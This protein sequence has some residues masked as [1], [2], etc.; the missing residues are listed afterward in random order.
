MKY[1]YHTST[2]NFDAL[3]CGMCI[4]PP[5]YY[6]E[7]ALWFPQYFKSGVDISS[8]I[9]ALYSN[10]VI[11][12]IDDSDMV[13]YPMV[14]ELDAAIVDREL[15]DPSH[16]RKIILPCG[17]ECIL[18]CVPIV[19]SAEDLIAGRVR[20]L[21]RS[22]S[23]K[24]ELVS[25]SNIGVSENKLANVFKGIGNDIVALIADLK[26]IDFNEVQSEVFDAINASGL[27]LT[28]DSF[29]SFENKDRQRGADAGF[30]AG[31]WV[32]SLREGFC[33]DCFPDAL[34]FASWKESLPKGIRAILDYVSSVGFRWDVNRN[35]ICNFCEKCWNACI[36]PMADGGSQD[37]ERWHKILGAIWKSYNDPTFCYPISKIQDPY[38]QALA[39]FM[40]AGRDAR[41]IVDIITREDILLPELSLSLHGALVGYCALSR[42]LFSKRSYEKE[43]KPELQV[44]KPR[45]PAVARELGAVSTPPA[46]I[47]PKSSWIQVIREKFNELIVEN[48]ISKTNLK[49]RSK[50]EQD[51]EEAANRSNDDANRF[52]RE[53]EIISNKRWPK[54][55]L[56]A[57]ADKLRYTGGLI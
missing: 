1:Y 50:L 10:P 56:K 31:W 15:S 9:V 51:I 20:F 7:D 11:W 45:K 47:K 54:K 43:C 3:Y 30:R 52:I 2:L 17:V 16:S 46:E 18:A 28:Q 6:Q 29:S 19:F 13:N 35:W 33:M 5:N 34:S 27:A 53:L 8:D 38:M 42:I 21:F 39:C 40:K 24:C 57:F 32:R 49:V 12:K 44:L 37:C 23:E 4:M 22:D 55:C 25:R 14:I 41:Q 36:K 26:T 48:R